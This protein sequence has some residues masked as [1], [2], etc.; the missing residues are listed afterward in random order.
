MLSIVTTFEDKY[1]GCRRTSRNNDARINDGDNGVAGVGAT[2]ME[3]EEEEEEEEKEEVPYK[4][5]IAMLCKLRTPH[6]AVA[7]ELVLDQ[8]E[9]R[10]CD[11]NDNGDYDVNRSGRSGGM[12]RGRRYGHSNPPTTKTYNNVMSCWGKSGAGCSAYNDFLPMTS[13]S[14]SSILSWPYAYHPNPCSNLLRR[15]LELY[16]LDPV[17]MR[18]MKPNYLL[19]NVAISLLSK[20]QM[21]RNG[22]GSIGRAC[23]DHLMSMLELYN[24]WSDAQCAPDLITF[25]TVLNVLGRGGRDEI[26]SGSG[27]G[28]KDVNGDEGRARKILDIMLYLGGIDDV[29][30]REGWGG[31][32]QDV[33]GSGNADGNTAWQQRQPDCHVLS[34]FI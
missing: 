8:F 22:R 19:F 1:V 18:R 12:G 31:G 5:I 21:Y 10:L 34:S 14:S 27:G 6:A 3:E 13:T 15:M 28:G 2:T 17:R 29:R 26:S 4:L 11:D 30:R 20:D 33:G 7:V 24:G 32:E 23:H 16:H 9:S 25:L